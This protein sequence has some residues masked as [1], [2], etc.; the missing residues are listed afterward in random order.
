MSAGKMRQRILV[1]ESS[2]QDTLKSR[3]TLGIACRS[4]A[5][6]SAASQASLFSNSGWS[7]DLVRNVEAREAQPRDVCGQGRAER[8]PLDAAPHDYRLLAR[9]I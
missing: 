3:T 4:R 9:Q 7:T 8:L 6:G 5:P 2:G 1:Q